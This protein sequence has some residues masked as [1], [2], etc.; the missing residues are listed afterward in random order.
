MDLL[1]QVTSDSN[2][3]EWLLT[4]FGIGFLILGGIIAW[5]ARSNKQQH[6]EMMEEFKKQ[7][8]KTSKDFRNVHRRI[9]EVL[10]KKV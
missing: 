9:D 8:K 7:A 3:N 5:L 10:K 1:A 6:T 4:E 2:I